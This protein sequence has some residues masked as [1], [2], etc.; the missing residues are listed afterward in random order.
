M[1]V[2]KICKSSKTHNCPSSHPLSD[3][4]TFLYINHFP[5]TNLQDSPFVKWL[6]L[7]LT[8]LLPDSFSSFLF[9]FPS[10]TLFVL[11][12][13]VQLFSQSTTHR[14]GLSKIWSLSHF[15]VKSTKLGLTPSLQFSA[16]G[17]TTHSLHLTRSHLRYFTSKTCSFDLLE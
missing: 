11:K 7:C 5:C 12:C 1:T 9:P 2:D 14:S 13:K 8:F 15:Q 10:N 17:S 6:F 4:I 16:S 3:A